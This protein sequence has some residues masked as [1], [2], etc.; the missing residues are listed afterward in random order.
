[1]DDVRVFVQS[2]PPPRMLL[3]GAIDFASAL[4]HVGC[5]SCPDPMVRSKSGSRTPTGVRSA[6]WQLASH[7]RQRQIQLR[8]AP[9]RTTRRRRRR[10]V[11]TARTGQRECGRKPPA[12]ALAT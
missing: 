10:R 12:L 11:E 8:H 5:R 2:A 3:F 9:L 7:F 6:H 4:A 1:M